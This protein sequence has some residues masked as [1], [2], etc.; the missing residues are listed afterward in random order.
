MFTSKNVRN[1][2]VYRETEA[3]GCARA[4]RTAGARA[5]A[6]VHQSQRARGAGRFQLRL[7]HAPRRAAAALQA[8]W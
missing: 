5:V 2:V 6:A 7:L 8:L 1:M 3:E 4:R